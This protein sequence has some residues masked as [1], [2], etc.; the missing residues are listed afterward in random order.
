MNRTR[1]MNNIIDKKGDLLDILPINL[2]FVF[3][4]AVCF[5]C[6]C[7]FCIRTLF[8][9][10]QKRNKFNDNP[11]IEQQHMVKTSIPSRSEMIDEYI[12][13]QN[14]TNEIFQEQSTSNNYHDGDDVET[15]K[16][17]NQDV[18]DMY[19]EPP[20]GVTRKYEEDDNNMAEVKFLCNEESDNYGSRNKSKQK[21]SHS[22]Q[23]LALSDSLN[24]GKVD[25]AKKLLRTNGMINDGEQHQ[26][27]QIMVQQ[28]EASRNQ[29]IF[30]EGPKEQ[31][32]EN[33]VILYKEMNDT[34]DV[35][36]HMTLRGGEFI[37]DGDDTMY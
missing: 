15:T 21:Q 9:I 13:S 27:N 23:P 1:M 32:N 25:I 20:A 31:N 2:L 24:G 36:E 10:Y 33:Q 11:Q 18:E 6:C 17:H 22:V 29:R 37:D 26:L 34:E 3:L 4:F 19:N 28:D 35:T 12:K 7:C 30:S 14:V 16:G 8:K 5:V